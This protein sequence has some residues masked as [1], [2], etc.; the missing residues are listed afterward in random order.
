MSADDSRRGPVLIEIEDGSATPGPDRAPPVPDGEDPPDGHAM[1]T[2]IRRGA[3]GGAPPS[4]L[5]RLFWGLALGLVGVAISVAAWD[6]ATG[7]IARLPVLGYAVAAMGVALVIVAAGLALRELAGMARLGR[8]DDLRRAAE[9]AH[10]AE[11][12]GAARAVVRR[13]RA[14]YAAR[15]EA[16]W[17]LDRLAA[18]EAEQFDA[19]AILGLAEAEVLAPL[20][21]RALDAVEQATRQVSLVTAMVPL[22]LAEVLG[23]AIA[24]LRMMRAVAEISRGRAGVLGSWRLARA[25]MAHLLATGAVAVGDDLISSVA[26]GGVL[27]RLSRRFGEGVVNGALTARVGV[28]AIEVGRPLPLLRRARPSVTGIV[29]RAMSGLFTRVQAADH[30]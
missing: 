21:A 29:R 14:L 2:V 28:A 8:L 30:D 27:S 6:F 26:G 19:D 25:V 16:R 12:P 10:D 22:A 4:R 15:P 3:G 17:G 23:A 1:Q 11:D 13:R 5:G 9:A 7:L 20:D 18:R 24:N